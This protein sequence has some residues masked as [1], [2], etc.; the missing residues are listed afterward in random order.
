MKKVWVVAIAIALL[1]AGCSSNSGDKDNKAS[2]SVEA[3]STPSQSPEASSS[4]EAS[5]SPEASAA[6]G[7]E[8]V[9]I[10]FPASLNQN[11]EVEGMTAEVKEAGATNI[12]TNGDG[13]VTATISQKN[14]D[15]L[16]EKYHSELMTM[17]EG[18]HSEENASSIKDLT[19]D[20][21]TF[22]EYDITVDKAAY[23]SA[24][25]MDGL[26][27]FGL[28]MQSMMYQIYSGVEETDLKVTFNLI[29]ESTGEIFD[30]TVLP[31]AAP[32]Q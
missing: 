17:I 28:A 31:E 3:S 2:S 27:I 29:D 5:K 30:T 13:S 8:E 9:N 25:S 15:K 19:Y 11:G 12:V 4:P 21:D 20:E 24:D 23:T 16:L 10:V 14:L 18:V 1:T 26:V 22:Q 6:P 7:E 32:A